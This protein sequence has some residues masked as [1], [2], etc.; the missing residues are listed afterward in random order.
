[1]QCL[2]GSV[3]GWNGKRVFHLDHHS[4]FLDRFLPPVP[5]IV[6]TNIILKHGIDFR[7]LCTFS[8]SKS[9]LCILDRHGHQNLSSPSGV[10]ELQW[11]SFFDWVALQAALEITI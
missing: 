8:V 10:P 1:M 9:E 7:H 6:T 2:E 5:C 3:R 11:Q 4:H